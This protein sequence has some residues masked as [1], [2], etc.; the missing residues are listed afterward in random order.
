MLELLRMRSMRR[1]AEA[2]RRRRGAAAAPRGA[3]PGT[4]DKASVLRKHACPCGIEP[5]S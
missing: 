5:M 3:A 1:V 4:L 2:L